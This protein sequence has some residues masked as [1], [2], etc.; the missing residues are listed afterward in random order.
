[1]RRDAAETDEP[2]AEPSGSFFFLREE[3]GF[4]LDFID[5]A[6]TEKKQTNRDAVRTGDAAGPGLL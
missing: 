6:A 4:Q 5:G 3:R 2:P 1:M